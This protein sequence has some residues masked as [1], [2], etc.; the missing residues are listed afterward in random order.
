MIGA[1]SCSYTQQQYI[2]ASNRSGTEASDTKK[3]SDAGASK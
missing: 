2:V 1:I 3:P